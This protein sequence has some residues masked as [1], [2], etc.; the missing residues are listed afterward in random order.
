MRPRKLVLA[1]PRGFCAG[2][3]RAVDVVETALRLWPLPIYV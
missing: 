3:R 1:A 2:V